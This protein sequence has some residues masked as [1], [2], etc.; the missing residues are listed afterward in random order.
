MKGKLLVATPAL[1]D[2][3]FVKSV[4][5]LCEH[6]PEGAMGLILNRALPLP[7]ADILPEA[8]V[9][10]GSQARLHQGG[11]VQEDHLLFLHGIPKPGLD[12]HPVCGGVFLG[13]DLNVLKKVLAEA[14]PPLFL[15]CYLGYAGWGAGQLEAEI[16][17]GAWILKPAR[18]KD[19]FTADP[20]TLWPRLLSAQAGALDPWLPPSGRDLN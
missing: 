3:N 4:I 19:V 6:G 9:P 1:T 18:D 16:E 11:P 15:R 2:P 10:P 5:L 8:F 20:A 13:G 12:A 14:K 17:Q 7:V